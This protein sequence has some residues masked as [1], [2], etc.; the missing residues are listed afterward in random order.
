MCYIFGREK[1]ERETHGLQ[2][3]EILSMHQTAIIM[4]SSLLIIPVSLTIIITPT[5]TTTLFL[6]SFKVHDLYSICQSRRAEPDQ[7][8]E[9]SL[10]KKNIY[11]REGL[12]L[13]CRLF[14]TVWNFS[15][16]QGVGFSR[17]KTYYLL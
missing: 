1:K 11:I 10:K 16:F 12:A 5:S 3:L 14:I 2:D 15:M 8:S 7:E 17:K 6:S 4:S 13:R 9:G